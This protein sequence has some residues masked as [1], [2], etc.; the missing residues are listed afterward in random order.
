MMS[1][2]PTQNEAS[3][4]NSNAISPTADNAAAAK[5]QFLSLLVAQISHQNPMK[6]MDDKDLITQ[7]AQF[8]SVEQAIE[9]NTRLA[10]LQESQDAASRINMSTLVGKEGTA[11]TGLLHVGSGQPPSPL[12]F[13]LDGRADQVSVRMLDSEGNVAH[14]IRTGAM[15]TGAHMMP[16]DGTL[17]TGQTIAAGDYAVKIT[18]TDKFGNTVPVR[19]E[20]RGTITGV[21]L[22][23]NEPYVRINGVK[24]RTSDVVQLN[25]N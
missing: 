17:T 12:A 6:P 21:D 7:L 4:G 1:L 9:T 3:T 8:S 15:E 5:E 11:Q 23:G 18:A 16:W 25:A 20:I 2:D 14:S 13:T 10:S 22:Q 19:Q 24:I